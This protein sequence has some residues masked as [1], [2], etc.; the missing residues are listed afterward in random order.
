[1]GVGLV[2][3]VRVAVRH[4]VGPI[5]TIYGYVVRVRRWLCM[6]A[7]ADTAVLPLRECDKLT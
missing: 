7:E 4:E 6:A 3:C 1:M 5:G 2:P